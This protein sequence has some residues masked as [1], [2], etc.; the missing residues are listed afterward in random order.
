MDMT[1]TK[2]L[3]LLREKMSYIDRFF[4][5]KHIPHYGEIIKLQIN[6]KIKNDRQD[7]IVSLMNFDANDDCQKELL[8]DKLDILN[9]FY[10]CISKLGLCLYE[11][12]S[13]TNTKC[14]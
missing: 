5:E 10:D 13:T 7:L 8:N 3:D 4:K 6:E 11:Q 12:I 2:K 9:M 14:L 1:T